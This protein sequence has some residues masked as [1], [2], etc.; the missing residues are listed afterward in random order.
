MKCA[1]AYSKDIVGLELNETQFVATSGIHRPRN[2]KRHTTKIT[3]L[4]GLAKRRKTHHD[5]E[6]GENDDPDMNYTE[7]YHNN[8]KFVL[9]LDSGKDYKCTGCGIALPTHPPRPFDLIVKHK[10]RYGYPDGAGRFVYTKVK[11]RDIVYHANDRCIKSRH[12]YFVANRLGINAEVAL[13]L[14]GVHVKLIKD[15]FAVDIQQLDI[16]G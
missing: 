16:L 7:P 5:N 1:R 12:P 14:A 10:E 6:G 11:M 2:N 15:H 13:S 9:V 8:C 4:K 3:G